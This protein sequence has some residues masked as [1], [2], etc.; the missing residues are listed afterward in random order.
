MRPCACAH[1]PRAQHST[2]VAGTKKPRGRAT[3]HQRQA[4]MLGKRKTEIATGEENKGGV[5]TC[6]CIKLHTHAS[7]LHKQINLNACMCAVAMN[8]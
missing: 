4:K 1:T 5:R 8:V 3:R 2:R 6:P 7:Q